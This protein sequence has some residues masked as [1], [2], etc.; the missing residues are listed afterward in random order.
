MAKFMVGAVACMWLAT[1]LATFAPGMFEEEI[2]A[3]GSG[4]GVFA[5]ILF[6][7]AAGAHIRFG[8][9]AHH[10]YTKGTL[11]LLFTSFV[12]P[13]VLGCLLAIPTSHFVKLSGDTGDSMTAALAMGTLVAVTALAVLVAQLLTS[14]RIRSKLG[15]LVIAMAIGHDIALWLLV[16]FLR[17]STLEVMQ[18]I[19]VVI[20]LILMVVS[21]FILD[22]ED[23]K[24]WKKWYAVILM[25]VAPIFSDEVGLHFLVG[26]V[27][28][29][30][31]MPNS[32]K[33]FLSKIEK[34]LM[35]LTVPYFIV[36]AGSVLNLGNIEPSVL[37]LAFVMCI[38][39]LV[40]QF[41]GSTLIARTQGYSWNDA[42]TVGSDMATKGV[43]E[44]A[45]A[46]SLFDGGSGLISRVLYYSTLLMA[47][48]LTT[49]S[50]WMSQYFHWRARKEVHE[51][52]V[53]SAVVVGAD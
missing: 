19:G 50:G 43:A 13:F 51:A 3:A 35:T 25:I 27:L 31:D 6:G 41:V 36:P 10:K 37:V 24:P 26:A 20:F 39:N 15:V 42:L 28:F 18:L 29:G 11:V 5:Q 9:H 49:L 44:Y 1:A 17:A 12:V 23:L 32:W 30:I 21:Y 16:A 47:M 52:Q 8:R 7:F 38:T 40:G 2:L 14:G 22:S 4:M 53:S 45:V 48:V 46:G 33:L 34:P